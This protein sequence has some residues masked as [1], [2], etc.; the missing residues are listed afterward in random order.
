MGLAAL[1]KGTL[2]C[3]GVPG[4]GQAGGMLIGRSDVM[5]RLG[6]F[7]LLAFAMAASAVQGAVIFDTLAGTGSDP[8]ADEVYK[9]VMVGQ[10]FTTSASCTLESITIAMQDKWGGGLEG[11]FFLRLYAS[12]GASS[13]PG[14]LLLT[15]VGSNAPAAAGDYTYTGTYGLSANTTYWAV[16]GTSAVTI[17]PYHWAYD[18]DFSPLPNSIG[19]TLYSADGSGQTPY[20]H[21]PYNESGKYYQMQVNAVPEPMTLA[22]LGLG[23]LLL[24]RRLA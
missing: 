18:Y 14:T 15:L 12:D 23:G 17:Y 11:D 19:T 4:T 22:V 2:I 5:N 21:A 16:A 10:S 6:I 24:R 9:N 13:T 1:A 7:G 3:L 8:G 20:W